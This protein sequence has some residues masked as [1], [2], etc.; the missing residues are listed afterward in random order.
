MMDS[1][2]SSLGAVGAGCS[3]RW[4]MTPMPRSQGI[5]R[6]HL[7]HLGTIGIAVA[8]PVYLT[9][10]SDRV[11]MALKGLIPVAFSFVF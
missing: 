4:Q 11:Q 5:R 7:D 1:S 9:A 2:S 3:T 10:N 8:I 6:G